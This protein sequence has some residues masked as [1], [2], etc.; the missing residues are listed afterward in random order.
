MLGHRFTAVCA[1]VV[2]IATLK[3]EVMRSDDVLAQDSGFS[4]QAP[5]TCLDRRQ[6]EN[7]GGDISGI[8]RYALRIEVDDEGYVARVFLS[9]QLIGDALRAESC[10]AIVQAAL[11][12]MRLSAQHER[13]MLSAKP[14]VEHSARAGGRALAPSQ[15]SVQRRP[16]SKLEHAPESKNRV[17]TPAA[18][19]AVQPKRHPPS[20]IDGGIT[21]R[22]GLDLFT[23][24][25][26]T[27]RYESGGY[28]HY[29]DFRIEIWGTVTHWPA[30]TEIG[31]H[32]LW[33]IGGGLGLCYAPTKSPGLLFNICAT[34]EM[35]AL[36]GTSIFGK[37]GSLFLSSIGV[38][39]R[40]GYAFGPISLVADADAALLFSRPRFITPESVLIRQTPYFNLKIMIGV[41]Y[42]IDFLSRIGARDTHR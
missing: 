16:R 13:K 3:L 32:F 35:G 11:L 22:I 18:P 8:E 23:L 33:M 17:R 26:V 25:A 21:Y 9:G 42:R 39:P 24:P 7:I 29:E 12:R 41:E 2:C 14:P 1:L 34:G 40:F 31:G 37:S 20:R 15:V 28:F 38:R 4:Y 6:V 5:P 30:E 36:N 10:D 19:R 27:P